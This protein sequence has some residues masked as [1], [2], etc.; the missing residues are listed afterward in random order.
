MRK[1]IAEEH[2]IQK[3]NRND[4]LI[5][6]FQAI[7]PI[8]FWM[9]LVIGPF[10]A[11]GIRTYFVAVSEQGIY[12]HLLS[13]FGKIRH[14]DFFTFDEI[15]NLKIGKGMIQRPMQFS[16]FNGRQLKVKAQLK[17]LDRVAK[18]KPE[19]QAYLENKVRIVQ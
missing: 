16:F 8:R 5:G 18:I 10:A 12:F 19:V 6:F 11:L 13:M 4:A 14:M 7:T 3:L 2:I 9:F 15:H 1:D 17:S